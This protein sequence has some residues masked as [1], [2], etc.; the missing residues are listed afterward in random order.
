MSATTDDLDLLLA[1]PARP[2]GKECATGWCIQR[3]DPAEADKVRAILARGIT[4]EQ[5][6]ALVAAFTRRDLP[7]ASMESVIRHA[8]G[9]CRICAER[10]S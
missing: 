4:R 3:L 5:A 7:W 8:N 6:R 1:A 10:A 9:G 2:G